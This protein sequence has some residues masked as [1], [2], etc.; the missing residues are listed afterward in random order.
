MKALFVGRFQP[1]HKGHL[2]AI[3]HVPENFDELVVIIGSSNESGTEKNPYSY[4][5]R[6]RMIRAFFKDAPVVPIPDVYDDDKWVNL[7]LKAVP[8]FDVVVTGNPWTQHC[9]RSR[10]FKVQEPDFLKP[11]IYNGTHIRQLQKEGKPW[12]DLVP[13]EVAELIS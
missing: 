2:H 12:K 1:F 5:L 4:E 10:G 9:F 7:I 6:E 8:D 11:D 13:E 3:K